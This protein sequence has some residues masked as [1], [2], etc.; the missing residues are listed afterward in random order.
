MSIRIYTVSGYSFRP[1]CRLELLTR[2][3]E[4]EDPES[5]RISGTE[6]DSEVSSITKFL[7]V[8][9]TRKGKCIA[10]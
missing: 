3:N 8:C 4:A 6:S 5:E 1:I 2:V 9:L 7:P 10:T